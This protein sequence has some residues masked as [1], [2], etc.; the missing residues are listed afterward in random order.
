MTLLLLLGSGLSAFAASIGD[1]NSDDAV[2]ASDAALVLQYAAWSGAGNQGSL[3]DYLLRNGR[4]AAS[5]IV[6]DLNSDDAVNASD[7][8][9]ILQFAAWSGAGNQGDLA[10]YLKQRGIQA[11]S[12]IEKNGIY[13]TPEEVAAYLHTFGTLPANYITKNEAKALGWVSTDGNLWD[14]APGKSIGGDYF[15]N[16]EG[17]L[18]SGNYKECDVNYNGGYRNAER[19]VYSDN[20][21]I[22]YTSDHYT[23]FT[24][25]Y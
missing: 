11:P 2:N 16:R 23:T 12:V 17:L 25:L 14:V 5:G 7:A 10:F 1:L 13:S 21:N 9:L 3:T 20:G 15:S 8:A 24:Q 18:P 4:P 6:G 19:L 22:Y